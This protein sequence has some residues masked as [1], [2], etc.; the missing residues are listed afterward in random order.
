MGTGREIRHELD[1]A[2]AVRQRG[3]L[4]QMDPGPGRLSAVLPWRQ[5][6]F[7]RFVQPDEVT[8]SPGYDQHAPWP[9]AP[10]GQVL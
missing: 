3:P 10:V 9:V 4:D 8:S 7:A 6:R 1:L 2:W 5:E